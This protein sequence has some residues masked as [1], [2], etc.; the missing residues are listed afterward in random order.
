[1]YVYKTLRQFRKSAKSK[2][3]NS[4]KKS[5]TDTTSQQ[6][7]KESESSETSDDVSV[8]NYLNFRSEYNEVLLWLQVLYPTVQLTV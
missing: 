7:V 1:M 8:S 3:S 4:K 6:K 2:L 5:N